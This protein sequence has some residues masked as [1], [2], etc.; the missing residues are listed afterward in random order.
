MK[1][2]LLLYLRYLIAIVIGNAIYF[3]IMP[4]LPPKAQH[5]PFQMDWGVAVDF[6]I[7]VAC[8]G[9]IRLIR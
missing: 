3:S 7:C 5:V 1:H 6:W 4:H 2:R 8:Y 9:V